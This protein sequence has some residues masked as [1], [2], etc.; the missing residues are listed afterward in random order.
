MKDGT[1]SSTVDRR[2]WMKKRKLDLG[3][4]RYAASKAP[5]CIGLLVGQRTRPDGFAVEI[6]ESEVKDRDQD[7]QSDVDFADQADK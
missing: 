3:N 6:E 4:P 7:L 5:S 2:K 1:R